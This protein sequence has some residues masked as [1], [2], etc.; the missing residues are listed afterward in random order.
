MPQELQALRWV[1]ALPPLQVPQGADAQLPHSARGQVR[2]FERVP[3]QVPPHG[4]S[5]AL[6][7]R[8]FQFPYH[9]L[10]KNCNSKNSPP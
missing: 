2:T 5:P 10:R 6:Q 1:W 3:L 9:T 8:G 4:Q 7:V